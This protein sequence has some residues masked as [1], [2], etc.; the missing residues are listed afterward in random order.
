MPIVFKF[1]PKVIGADF[2]TF[3]DEISP[4]LTT[5]QKLYTKPTRRTLTWYNRE[6]VLDQPSLY[7]QTEKWVEFFENLK[8]GGLS[9]GGSWWLIKALYL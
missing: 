4:R 3:R 2:F 6:E 9:A 8:V 7:W 1:S 5:D